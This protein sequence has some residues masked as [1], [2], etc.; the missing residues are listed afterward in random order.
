MRQPF[1]MGLLAVSVVIGLGCSREA[2]PRPAAEDSAPGNV[3]TADRPVD[4][5]K[6]RRELYGAMTAEGLS[7]GARRGRAERLVSEFPGTPE[8]EHAQEVLESVEVYEAAKREAKVAD[9]KW[10]YIES[11]DPMSKK[12]TRTAMLQSE[13]TLSF[14]FPYQGPQRATLRVRSHPEFGRDVIVSIEKGQIL[15]SSYDCPMRIV[16][17]DGTPV[18]V[19]GSS[20]ADHDSTVVFLPNYQ[21]LTRQI[22]QASGMRV[23]VNMYQQGAPTLIFDVTGFNPS[24]EATKV[25]LPY[26]EVSARSFGAAEPEASST[27]D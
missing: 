14:G 12:V 7:P 6:A 27:A 23:Q 22:A 25:G 2:V 11:T 16:F 21:R 18:S 4:Q 5:E 15:C 24:L 10:R 26:P 8:A 19:Q 20:S 1:F 9:G 3:G 13:N 17:D